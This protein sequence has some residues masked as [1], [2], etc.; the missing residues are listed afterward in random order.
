MF[1]EL[2]RLFDRSFAVGYFLPAVVFFS[3][4]CVHAGSVYLSTWTYPP[5]KQLDWLVLTT[6][7]G[8]LSLVGGI[9]LAGY[10]PGYLQDPRGVRRTEIP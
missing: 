3:I 10:Q 7:L 5:F 8:L 2:S 1:G 6:V 9:V 4:R